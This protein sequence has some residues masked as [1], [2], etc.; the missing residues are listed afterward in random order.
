MSVAVAFLM[1]EV[2]PVQH[3]N[4]KGSTRLLAETAI[5][6]KL[7]QIAEVLVGLHCDKDLLFLPF[8][9]SNVEPC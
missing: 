4:E 1:E 5:C 7:G 8:L 3:P 6:D 9:Y 2:K